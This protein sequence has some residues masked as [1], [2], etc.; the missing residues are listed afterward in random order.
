MFAKD[1]IN[2]TGLYSSWVEFPYI[3]DHAPVL[4]QLDLPPSYKIYPFKFNVQWLTDKGF[5]DIVFKAWNDLIFL[6]KS[7][8][9]RRIIWKL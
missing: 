4:L 6:T 3:S 8:K 7:G 2:D 1:L 5:M 9:Q